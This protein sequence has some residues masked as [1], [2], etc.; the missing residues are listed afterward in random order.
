[1]A[2]QSSSVIHILIDICPNSDCFKTI[3]RFLMI[4]E[5]VIWQGNDANPQAVIMTYLLTFP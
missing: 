5:Y 1:M 2:V 4:D 3:K